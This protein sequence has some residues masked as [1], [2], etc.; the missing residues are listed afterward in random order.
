MFLYPLNGAACDHLGTFT[1][2][3][4]DNVLNPTIFYVL[5]GC[6]VT[7]VAGANLW[8]SQGAGAT[9]YQVNNSGQVINTFSCP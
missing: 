9:S 7:P 2:Y 5:G 3:D 4:T 8:F 1:Q 6:G